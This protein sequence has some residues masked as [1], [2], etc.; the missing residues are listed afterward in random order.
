MNRK[1]IVFKDK[2]E[3]W[4]SMRSSTLTDTPATQLSSASDSD[5]PQ[6]NRNISGLSPGPSVRKLNSSGQGAGSDHKSNS[7]GQESGS[8]S[9]PA[10]KKLNM[11]QAEYMEI[12][13]EDDE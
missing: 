1:S 12:L 7:S 13:N 4:A 6:L 8:G 2:T 10:W 5:R 9:V 11:T 3:S